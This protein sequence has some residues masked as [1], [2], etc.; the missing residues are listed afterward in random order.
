MHRQKQHTGSC[1]PSGKDQV[2]QEPGDNDWGRGPASSIYIEKTCFN[3]PIIY[4]QNKHFA[5]NTR[6]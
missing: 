6:L 3:M 1:L 4:H 5:K 2:V